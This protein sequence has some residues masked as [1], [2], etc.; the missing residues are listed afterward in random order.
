MRAI[1]FVGLGAMGARMARRLVDAGH[2]VRVWNRTAAKAEPL[3]AAG[4]AVA[5]SAAEAAA[6]SELAITM[7]RDAAALREVT[8]GPTGLLAGLRPGSLLVEM[9][10]VGPAAVRELAAR[11]PSGAALLDAPVL[12]SVDEAEDGTLSIFVGGAEGD[13]RRASAVLQTL[14]EPLHV[15]PLGS[16]AAAKLVANSTL[17]A[18]I[19]A[20]GE[21]VA[22][23]DALGLER[24]V[25]FAVL[26]ATPLAA[27]AARRR[28]ALEADDFPARFPLSLARKDAD[29]ILAASMEAGL[30][31]GAAAAARARLAEADD[32]GWGDRDYSAVL[33]WLLR[34]TRPAR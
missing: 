15:G 2:E 26:D 16:G 1:G 21:A 10:T 32:A 8:D 20:L 34:L 23:G 17:L 4:A 13:F 30:D 33:A 25:T 7:V 14:G 28:P 11:L 31:L 9:S 3:A 12:G 19:S 22:L 29:L 6:G 24:D 27:Q 18:T 5:A